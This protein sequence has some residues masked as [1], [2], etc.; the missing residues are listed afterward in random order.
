MMKGI[1]VKSNFTMCFMGI[2]V[3]LYFNMAQGQENYTPGQQYSPPGGQPP[4][5]EFFPPMGPFEP[6]PLESMKNFTEAFGEEIKMLTY[7]LT[8]YRT[9]NE[10]VHRQLTT[11]RVFDPQDLVDRLAREIEELLKT[12]VKAVEKLVKAA[13]DARKD[14]EYRKHLQLEYVNNKKL[15][16]QED[17]EKTGINSSSVTDIYTMIN[18]TQDTLFNN[19]QI[20]PNY[21]TIHVPT[22]VYDQAPVILNGIQ[23]SK[24]LDQ[25]F[26]QNKKETSDLRWQYYCSADGFLR[27]YPGVKW[28]MN[29]GEE[30]VDM[31]DCRV[32]S[33]Y[34][35]AASSPK[36]MVI[37]VDTSG[38]MKGRRRIITVKTI[39]KLLETL[40]DDDHFNII[41]Y[42]DKPRYL[43]NC[44]SGTLMQANIQNKQR[45]VKLFKK[46]EM[47]DTG[48][49]NL[50]LEEAFKLFDSEKK[51][52]GQE[53]C[54]K[55]IMVITDGPSETY[56]EIF[57]KHNWPNKTVRLF[58]FLVGREVKENRY[59]K[60]MACANK[61]YYTHI[62]TL[63]DVQES[64]QYYLR[65]LSRPMGMAHREGGLSRTSKWTPVYA[66]YTTEVTQNLREGVGL[67]ISVSMPVF[68][69]SNSSATGGRLLGVMGTDIPIQEITNLVPKGKLGANAYTFMYTHHGYV[70]FHPNMKPM[71]HK[72]K[73]SKSAEKEFR[74]F[75]NTIDITEMEYAVDHEE[76]HEF[77]QKLLSASSASDRSRI[78]LKVKV[79]Y[80]RSV[81]YDRMNRVE[82]VTHSYY[83]ASI[84]GTPYKIAIALPSYSSRRSKLTLMVKKFDNVCTYVQ[85]KQKQ[86][87]FAPWRYCGNNEILHATGF[88][89]KLKILDLYKCVQGKGNCSDQ[90]SLLYS[91]LF[92]HHT[93]MRT[94][95]ADHED[96]RFR[97]ANGLQAAGSEYSTEPEYKKFYEKNGI[98]LLFI[99]TRGGLTDF[100]APK[101]N[102]ISPYW[103]GN[104]T[105]TIEELYYR[106]AIMNKEE[107]KI[108]YTFS[109]RLNKEYMEGDN[110]T[111]LSTI[112]VYVNDSNIA[113]VGMM[114]N[115]SA[116]TDIF[117]KYLFF[118]KCRGRGCF[119]CEGYGCYLLDENG[120]IVYAMDGVS[121]FLGDT[122][123]LGLMAMLIKEGVF[124]RETYTDYQSECKETYEEET[125]EEGAS[126]AS[127]LLS[128]FKRLFDILLWSAVE[129]LIT[130]AKVGLSG[131][132]YSE[133]ATAAPVNDKRCRFLGT[134]TSLENMQE[135]YQAFARAHYCNKE[136]ENIHLVPCH[137]T[138]RAYHANF[139]VFR[140]RGGSVKGEAK[141]CVP[142]NCTKSFAAVWIRDTN[143][144]LV[145]FDQNCNCSGVVDEVA[146]MNGD[147]IVYNETERCELMQE[148]SER[149]QVETTC[150]DQ[151]PKEETTECGCWG[152]LASVPV[153]VLSVALTFWFSR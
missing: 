73:G 127:L 28:P 98:E 93:M 19:V 134:N 80:D 144:I 16:S 22:N 108:D 39:Q 66:D 78:K 58:S 110:M 24:K 113:V 133:K 18:L 35:K 34:I 15:L 51:R 62:S 126:S 4:L 140:K 122:E 121:K 107:K 83:T 139:T 36:N 112:P 118:N 65:V 67:V 120:Y 32:R 13:E 46:L 95:I 25:I 59:A 29:N 145:S 72:I 153:L 106:Q 116:F 90:D 128:P 85:N 102:M 88:D 47:K 86:Y 100:V 7:N 48:E 43:D 23:W 1:N 8:A 14:H 82:V 74:P 11:P 69:T 33:W 61:G 30:S 148:I 143:L 38:S 104:M 31:Y 60:W 42:S 119:T 54:N 132:F 5:E 53:Q 129:F 151:N 26:K 70:L 103:M 68:D 77:R 137:I 76:L 17:L 147:P 64:V 141:G 131:W 6:F 105:A 89:R 109:I 81:P 136:P 115:F 10:E 44:F 79:P 101:E 12:K 111:I 3:T 71:Y 50:A 37:L 123:D 152:L 142:S 146:T 27:I 45:A 99:A 96:Y 124:I 114:Q 56:K 135:E 20:N 87:E 75:F 125:E 2:I 91:D 94:T 84:T 63:A 138:K 49:L 97:I 130:F 55:A 21:S 57:E 150:I 41:T 52:E 92:V 40:S 9:Y 117:K 149:V